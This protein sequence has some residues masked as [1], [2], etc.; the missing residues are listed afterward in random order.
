MGII[1]YGPRRGSAHPGH[2]QTFVVMRVDDFDAVGAE[3]STERSDKQ[4][5]QDEQLRVR[6]TR[7]TI[8]IPRHVADP[9]HFDSIRKRWIAHVVRDDVDLVASLQQGLGEAMD[10]DRRASPVGKWAGRYHRDVE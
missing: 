6:G 3:Y 10:P 7:F 9:V 8:T 2:E 1:D 5:I 4:R